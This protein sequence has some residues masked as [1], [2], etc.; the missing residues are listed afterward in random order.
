MNDLDRPSRHSER[1]LNP[2]PAA[3]SRDDCPGSDQFAQALRRELPVAERKR[4]LDH[5]AGC[6]ACTLAWRMAREFEAEFGAA[7]NRTSAGWSRTWLAL[8]AT[9]AGVALLLTVWRSSGGIAPPH[10]LTEQERT[11][12]HDVQVESL[13][14]GQIERAALENGFEFRWRIVPEQPG[15]RYQFTLSTRALT[16]LQ[17]AT[18]LKTPTQR[19]PAAL[20]NRLEPPTVV[21]WRVDVLLPD[22]RLIAGPTFRLSIHDPVAETNP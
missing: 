3:T 11:A 14:P 17:S 22:G 21:L 16:V 19:A 18:D 13:V 7:H 8:A 10:D 6:A 2:P 15:A 4:L 9:L 20:F 1:F 12:A 5:I